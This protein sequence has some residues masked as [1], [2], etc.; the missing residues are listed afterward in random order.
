[1]AIYSSVGADAIAPAHMQTNADTRMRMY[2]RIRA[3]VWWMHAITACTAV[4]RRCGV[5]A[6]LSARV[7]STYVSTHTW[8]YVHTHVCAQDVECV[9][10]CLAIAHGWPSRPRSRPAAQDRMGV[11]PHRI[12]GVCAGSRPLRVPPLSPPPP[13]PSC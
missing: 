5:D 8:L 6:S 10:A 12:S 11:L 3:Y 9:R 4:H 13:P 7:G 2:V 1:M